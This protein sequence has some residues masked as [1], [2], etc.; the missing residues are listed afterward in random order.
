MK[1]LSS[2]LTQ[3]VGLVLLLAK[4]D[5]VRLDMFCGKP[6]AGTSA[7]LQQGA[8]VE[9]PALQREPGAPN[10]VVLLEEDSDSKALAAVLET[11]S[12][13]KLAKT[14]YELD[15]VN[16]TL[17]TQSLTPLMWAVRHSKEGMLQRILGR[18]ADP[19]VQ[20]CGGHIAP[21]CRVDVQQQDP[22]TCDTLIGS[23]TIVN[24]Q[25]TQ[26][27]PLLMEAARQQDEKLIQ[28]L[29]DTQT[30]LGIQDT[31]KSTALVQAL[32]KDYHDFASKLINL[33]KKQERGD[34]DPKIRALIN[35]SGSLDGALREAAT[36]NQPLLIEALI[37]RGADVNDQSYFGRT[38]LILAAKKGHIEAIATLIK[39]GAN[40]ND[41][42]SDRS[43][44]M[45]A[46][47]NGHA[48]AIE[49]LIKHKA[50][51]SDKSYF[52]RT[53]L[54]LAAQNGRTE[55][56]ESLIKHG[57]SVNAADRFGVTALIS[58]V[59]KNRIDCVKILLKNMANTELNTGKRE[60]I[61]FG[62][63]LFSSSHPKESTA[64]SIA[65]RLGHK[66]VARWIK[67]AGALRLLL[68]GVG[69]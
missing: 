43:A 29:I 54:M 42:G 61:D 47:L 5:S 40:I 14:S 32:S 37:K 12:K 44:L 66:D 23:N 59:E 64:L 65:Q 19:V 50:D 31:P 11:E 30:D 17:S 26:G 52:G 45:F 69:C 34:V 7:T 18:G 49:V 10:G 35:S 62:F 6:L 48:K 21:L 33:Q 39:F 60:C 55:A 46:A 51:V 63:S 22:K 9:E 58:A 16:R 41:Q 68:L 3:G 1:N 8:I 24:A 38:A 15:S 67:K 13:E 25:S 2:V 4:C 53:A 28:A 57:A 36:H 27:E 56:V 20:E